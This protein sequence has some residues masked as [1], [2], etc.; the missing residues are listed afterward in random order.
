M[1]E[2]DTIFLTG[3]EA[4]Q[5]VCLDFQRYEPQ[6]ML[7]SEVLRVLTN[8]RAVVKSEKG[9][10]GRWVAP[11][12]GSRMVWLDGRALCRYVC[13]ALRSGMPDLDT[14]AAIC[15]RVFREKAVRAV[16]PETGQ[17]GICIATGM[18]G[19]SCKQCGNC[20]RSLDYHDALTAQ[21]V[22]E[23]KASGRHDILAW[24]SESRTLGGESAFHIWTDP[25]TG[26]RADPCPFLLKVPEK[27]RWICRIHSEK[28][29]IC[30]DYPVSRKHG[31][32]T[33]CQGFGRS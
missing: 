16:D 18:E 17:A 8:D 20:C 33:G 7:F 11:D 22:D 23:W 19:F 4:L 30:R 25:D 32:M 6:V 15:S 9:K 28:P 1:H 24:V 26:Q 10:T 27:N 12:G 29:R 5:A 21:D 14:L 2:K 13:E 31:L 3:Q